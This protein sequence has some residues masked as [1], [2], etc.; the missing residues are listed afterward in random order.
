MPRSLLNVFDILVGLVGAPI[1][2]ARIST[3]AVSYTH[4]IAPGPNTDFTNIMAVKIFEADG[5]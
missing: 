5:S 2:E 4:L 3:K 1:A